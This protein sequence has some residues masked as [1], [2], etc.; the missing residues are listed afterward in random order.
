[1]ADGLSE[2]F[3][4]IAIILGGFIVA[5]LSFDILF[6]IMGAIQVVSIVLLLPILERSID[7]PPNKR[8]KT[9]RHRR[10]RNTVHIYKPTG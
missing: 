2:L 5:Y 7:L 6:L 10:R 8:T 3:T 1:M 4:G 9:R